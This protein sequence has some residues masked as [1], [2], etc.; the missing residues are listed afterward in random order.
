[1]SD[2]YVHELLVSRPLCDQD[3]LAAARITVC[4]AG[5]LGSHLAD[6]LARQGA[7]K[8]AVVDFDRVEAHNVGTQLYRR[9]EVA[10]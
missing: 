7:A 6:N 10:G 9:D 3:K 4:G 5:A 2:L 1:M 8:L